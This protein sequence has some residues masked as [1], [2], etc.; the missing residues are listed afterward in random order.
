MTMDEYRRL[1]SLLLLVNYEI[2]RARF[3][4]ESPTTIW[5]TIRQNVLQT[6][7]WLENRKFD[8]GDPPEPALVR[9]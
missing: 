7:K 9:E 3:P 2:L 5:G 8:Q 1:E 6:D 4:M